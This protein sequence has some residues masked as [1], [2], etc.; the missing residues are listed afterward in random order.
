MNGKQDIL[1]RLADYVTGRLEARIPEWPTCVLLI[2]AKILAQGRSLE[3]YPGWYFAIGES[4]PDVRV[5]LRS[6]VWKTCNSRKVERPAVMS[7]YDGTRLYVYL[8][9]DVSRCLF[10][11]GC[12]E[13]NE[14]AFLDGV[15][16]PGMVF[17]DVGAND[18]L[19]SLFASRRVG[20]EGTV[21]AIEPSGREFKRL[22]ANIR[23]NALTNVRPR[24]VA[25]SNRNGQGILRIAGYEHAGQNT[26][27]AFLHASVECLH[28]ERVV[29]QRLDDLLDHEGVKH[30]DL[31]KLDVEGA[32]CSALEGAQRTLT[33][34]RPL[35]LLEL[36]DAALRCQGSS[37][38]KVLALLRAFDYEIYT[39]D[40]ASGRPV[41][42][43]RH[44]ELSHNIV[45]VHRGRTW[46][47]LGARS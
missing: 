16:E 36:S 45:A 20:V 5:R 22:Q 29:L 10:I 37:D 31:I 41:K 17:V 33:T 2:L 13:P 21:L 39:F 40:K 32:E 3:P 38:E 26:L 19:Y 24:Q 18:G 30:V 14:F 12:I 43:H 46:G 47:A 9:N 42:A 28:T 1:A 34:S 25:L 44:S 35:L 7:W 11:G 15:I 6:V 8:G 4:D 23:L 27:G